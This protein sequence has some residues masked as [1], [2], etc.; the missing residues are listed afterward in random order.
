MLVGSHTWCWWGPAGLDMTDDSAWG[1]APWGLEV[2]LAP[3]LQ[4]PLPELLPSCSA[5]WHDPTAGEWRGGCQSARLSPQLVHES[6]GSWNHDKPGI[7]VR[8]LRKGE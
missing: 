5:S 8:A 6:L 3:G 7:T 1:Q 4:W 2:P